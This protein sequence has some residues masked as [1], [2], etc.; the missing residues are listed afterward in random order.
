MNT[1]IMV[2]NSCIT[3]YKEGVQF[4]LQSKGLLKEWIMKIITNEGKTAAPISFIFCTDEKLFEINLKYLK[5]SELTD[6]I[7][8]DYGDPNTVSGDVFISFDRV[9][10][11]ANAFKV[12]FNNELRRVMVHGTLHLAGFSDKT[13]QEKAEMTRKE[14]LYLSLFPLK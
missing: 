5:T 4:R 8:F 9:I 14:D 11:N 13:K 1:P 7:T 12:S 6:V 2:K 10:E 3:F